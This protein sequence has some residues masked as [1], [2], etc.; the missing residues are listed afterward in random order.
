MDRYRNILSLVIIENHWMKKP[1]EPL[2]RRAIEKPLLSFHRLVIIENHWIQLCIIKPIDQS[3]LLKND[4][5]YGLVE[6]IGVENALVNPRAIETVCFKAT[7]RWWVLHCTSHNLQKSSGVGNSFRH[8][9]FSSFHFKRYVVLIKHFLRW[10]TTHEMQMVCA[11][12]CANPASRWYW[13]SPS[14]ASFATRPRMKSKLA[15]FPPVL[16]HGQISWAI[17]GFEWA[18]WVH[19]PP[20][21][22]F[23]SA[24]IHPTQFANRLNGGLFL[25]HIIFST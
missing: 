19:Q 17:S 2:V 21:E 18:R 10:S 16:R 22:L 12:T 8:I 25:L 3:S 6:T 24:H 15:Q 1:F 23:L 20:T 5:R 14:F 7:G 13:H 11:S 9:L 4:H